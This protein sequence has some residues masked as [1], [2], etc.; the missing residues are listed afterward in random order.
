M[1]F[2]KRLDPQGPVILEKVVELFYCVVEFNIRK[3]VQYLGI[4]VVFN[5]NSAID[6]STLRRSDEKNFIEYEHLIDTPHG[7]SYEINL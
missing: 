4:S 5:I 6:I 7:G 2:L 3:S 1:F